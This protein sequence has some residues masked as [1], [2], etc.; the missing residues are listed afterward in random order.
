MNQT[1]LWGF[2]PD[3]TGGKVS[4]D[5]PLTSH[6]AAAQVKSGSQKA[7]MLFALRTR[8]NGMTG[9]ELSDL[10][11]NTAGKPISPNQA[12]TRLLELREVGLVDYRREFSGGPVMERVTTPGN[13]GQ[14]HTL[15]S[16]GYTEAAR[17]ATG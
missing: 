15:T 11:F 9:F 2:D 6:R 10:V 8:P 5:H 1:T 13:T 7:Q 3:G 17:L 4:N 14:V 12:C 16:R